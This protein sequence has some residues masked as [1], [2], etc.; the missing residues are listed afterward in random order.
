MLPSPSLGPPLLSPSWSPPLFCGIPPPPPLPEDGAEVCV[1]WWCVVGWDDEQPATSAA[2]S[3]RLPISVLLN[4]LDMRGPL[5]VVVRCRRLT[6]A[7]RH[8]YEYGPARHLVRAAPDYVTRITLDSSSP[9]SR[10]EPNHQP[11]AAPAASA[12]EATG[13]RRAAS[14]RRG[15]RHRPGQTAASSPVPCR[16]HR[17][18][19]PTR[20]AATRRPG[21][22]AR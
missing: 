7:R 12:R 6:Q 10:R 9:V 18:R 22:A 2:S 8:E 14:A 5:P 3:A 20:A 11:T 19:S 1:A 16:R 17:P 13:V 4:V 21:P 15:R